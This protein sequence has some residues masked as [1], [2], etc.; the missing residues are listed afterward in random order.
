[1]AVLSEFYVLFNLVFYF[2]G[3][4]GCGKTFV[5]AFVAL[6]YVMAMNG[7]VLV[8]TTTNAAADNFCFQALKLINKYKIGNVRMLR[9][10]SKLYDLDMVGFL[11]LV[12]CS[13][14]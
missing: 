7:K 9:K 10:Y 2:K 3:P 12:L 11:N 1:M 8:V 5:S 4:P 14:F 6:F 13:I